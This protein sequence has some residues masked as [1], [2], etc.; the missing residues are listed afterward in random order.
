MIKIPFHNKAYYFCTT[1]NR[2]FTA[3]HCKSSIKPQGGGGGGAL[4]MLGPKRGGH[5]S[6]PKFL[7]SLKLI[8]LV[9]S[10]TPLTRI[11]QA[12]S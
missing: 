7:S 1:N 3:Y 9:N 6:N 4:L 2:H 12:M 10:F 11:G 8:F 5:I